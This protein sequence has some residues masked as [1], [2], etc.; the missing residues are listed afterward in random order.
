VLHQRFVT[1]ARLSTSGPEAQTILTPPQPVCCDRRNLELAGIP[2][3]IIDLSC[4][5]P[6]GCCDVAERV[7]SVRAGPSVIESMREMLRIAQDPDL[8]PYIWNQGG[9]LEE[10]EPCR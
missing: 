5:D 3:A 2:S 1:G 7:R 6:A 10:D 4:V 8:R 9:D